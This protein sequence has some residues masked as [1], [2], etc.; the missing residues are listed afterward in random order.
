MSNPL[1]NALPYRRWF[2][3]LLAGCLLALVMPYTNRGS[4]QF[5]SPS[6]GTFVQ[7]EHGLVPTSEHIWI[8]TRTAAFLDS[9]Q[10]LWFGLLPV[11]FEACWI[12]WFVVRQHTARP[13]N[14]L[15]RTEAGGG[16]SSE[17]R[18]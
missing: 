8:D 13:N 1:F 10:W 6:I 14:A 9:G 16:A 4:G 17:F 7:T 3:W 18:P 15:Q 5:Y 12:A 2:L 11:V